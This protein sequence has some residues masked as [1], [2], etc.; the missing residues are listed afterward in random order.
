MAHPLVWMR[1]SY[2]FPIGDWPSVCLTKELRPEED[3]EIL[4]LGCGDPRSILFT[5]YH[6]LAPDYRRLDVTC[7]DWEPAVIARN[8]IILTMIS[9]GTPTETIWSIYFHLF[10]EPTAYEQLIA[11]CRTLI[12][13]SSDLGA[14]KVSKYGG[15]IR[16][17]TERSFA[18]VR[19]YWVKYSEVDV[20]P[21]QEKEVIRKSF[22]AEMELCRKR[23]QSG[24]ILNSLRSSGPIC[25]FVDQREASTSYPTYWT[26]GTTDETPISPPHWNPTFYYASSGGGF[27]VFYGIEP[28]PAFNLSPGLIPVKAVYS[29]PTPKIRDV[30]KSA[31][32]QFYL[33]CSAFKKRIA[34]GRASNLVLRFHVGEAMAFS[35]ALLVC[36]RTKSTHSGAYVMQ[37]GGAQIVL[38]DDDYAGNGTSAPLVFNV[39][40]TSNLANHLGMLNVLTATVPLLQQKPWAT[41]HTDILVPLDLSNGLPI[42]TLADHVGDIPSISLALGVAPSSSLSHFTTYSNKHELVAGAM[43]VCAQ[44]RDRV[45]WRAPSHVVSGFVSNDL[46]TDLQRPV[47]QKWPAKDLGRYLFA[48][49]LKIFDDESLASLGTLTAANLKKISL[50]QYTREGLVTF[51]ALVKERVKSNWIDAV[52]SFD[53][54][55][56]ADQTLLMGNT[57]YQDFICQLYLYD[58]YVMDSMKSAFLESLRGRNNLFRGWKDIPPVVTAILKVPRNRMKVLEEMSRD[59]VGTPI[60][61]CEMRSAQFHNVYSSIRPVFGKIITSLVDGE[62]S[63]SIDEDLREWDGDSDLIV[64]FYLQ[65]WT[66]LQV[67][68]EAVEIALVFKSTPYAVSALASTLGRRLCIYSTKL[69]DSENVLLVRRRPNNPEE[70]N[71]YRVHNSSASSARAGQTA[72]ISIDISVPKVASITV[73][74]NITDHTARDNLLSGVAVDK[75]AIADTAIQVYIDEYAH[76]FVYPFPIRTDLLKVRIARKSSYVEIEAPVRS[77]FEDTRN[78]SINLFPIAREHKII[79]LLNMHYVN[80][81]TLPALQIPSP[82]HRHDTW[83]IPH[84]GMTMT[85][86]ERE[87]GKSQ[88]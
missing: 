66:L 1:K 85:Q 73:R 42:T 65:S 35:R 33:W 61:Q 19:S 3:A 68:P 79:N 54:L 43:H 71:C 51:M 49:Y 26:T 20:L 39:I 21:E 44:T 8:I 7:C 83:L 86:R 59:S 37:W 50:S 77:D 17:C 12:Q 87:D 57:H 47:I 55:Q 64:T 16:F 52:E 25:P 5:V 40:D 48:I 31:K 78:P 46:A 70:L 9:D 34:T 29:P 58:V 41:L 81:D 28:L 82:H 69:S 18:D 6:D 27:S 60:L 62:V 30:V 76:T 75:E 38:D 80:L 67:P 63:V 11:H 24:N 4:L 45:V 32:G 56:A 14:W 15:Y 72:S 23:C 74:H 10:L 13:C 22:G 2:F 36:Q 53:D 84:L 88:G